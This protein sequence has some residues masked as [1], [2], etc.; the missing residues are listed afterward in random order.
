MALTAR[1]I[2]GLSTMAGGAQ[3][4]RLVRGNLAGHWW[5]RGTNSGAGIVNN[6]G[7]A[8]GG[9]ETTATDPNHENFCGYGT[10]TP[11]WTRSRLPGEL[12]WCIRS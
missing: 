7:L 6:H 4:R 12:Y 3:F 11:N 9:S 2:A 8:L 10:K 1:F 5:T